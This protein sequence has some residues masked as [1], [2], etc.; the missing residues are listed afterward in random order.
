MIDTMGKNKALWGENG[1]A[2]GQ[3]TPTINVIMPEKDKTPEEPR[4]EIAERSAG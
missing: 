1:Q 2:D 4:Q 3:R